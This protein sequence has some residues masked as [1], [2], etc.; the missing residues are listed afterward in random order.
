MLPAD[1]F[2]PV[3]RVRR[4]RLGTDPWGAAKYG[5]EERAALPPALLAWT[6]GVEQPA[7]AVPAAIQ[8]P[9]VLWPDRPDV[10]VAPSD[11]LIIGGASWTVTGEAEHWP[12]GTRVLLK[13]VTTP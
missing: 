11:T 1:W 5:P 4:P 8:T 7:G 10:D 6:Q 12:M 3:V 2:V 13:R 9:L